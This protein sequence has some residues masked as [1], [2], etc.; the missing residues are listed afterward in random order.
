MIDLSHKPTGWL[1]RML[2]VPLPFTVHTS[3]SSS[4]CRFVMIE[5]LGRRGG[6]RH[7]TVVEVGGGPT[8]AASVGVHFRNR[9]RCRLVSPSPSGRP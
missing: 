9:T 4:G 6:A 8:P 2:K 3:A 7:F 5:R 1:K